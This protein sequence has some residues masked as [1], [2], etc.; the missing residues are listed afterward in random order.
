MRVV[1]AGVPD[2]AVASLR[3][4]VKSHHEV[5]LAVTQPDRAS[6]RGRRLAP[7]P[8]KTAAEELGVPV[9]QP[10]DVN[11]DASRT[12]LAELRPDVLAVVAGRRLLALPGKGCVNVHGSLLPRWRGAAP[13]A[14]A[15]LHGDDET[16]VTT[17]RMVRKMDA[18]DIL[19]QE[20]TPIGPSETEGKLRERLTPLGARLLVRTL[21]R[22]EANAITPRP[23]DPTQVTFAPTLTKRDGALDWTRPAE[24]IRDRVRGLTPWP[25]AYTFLQ[26][27]GEPIRLVILA[28]EVESGDASAGPGQVLEAH[29][30]RL[31]VAAGAG[32][33]SLT[34]LQRAGKKPMDAA[35]LLRGLPIEPGETLEPSA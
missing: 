22:I 17:Q 27:G 24:E 35:A 4:L 13:I 19:L 16:G 20:R 31:V 34:R 6:G 10:L 12:R 26:R 14:Y 28:S 5:L 32:A 15:L 30:D 23:Q 11:S 1:F 21:D 3:A 7:P 25:S 18:G 33:L 9:F 2:F 8:V 29:G